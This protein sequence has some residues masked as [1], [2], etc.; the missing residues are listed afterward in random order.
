MP[1]GRV[2]LLP[3]PQ[4]LNGE[5]DRFA[6]Q[7]ASRPMRPDGDPMFDDA[8]FGAVRLDGDRVDG[9]IIMDANR[10]LMELSGGRATPGSRFSDLFESDEEGPT[11]SPRR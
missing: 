9:A 2:I 3:S 7:G 5:G 11:P 10:A 8:P 6:L 1:S 4:V